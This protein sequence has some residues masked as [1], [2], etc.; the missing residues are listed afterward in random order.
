M[1]V[2]VMGNREIDLLIADVIDNQMLKKTKNGLLLTQEEIDLLKKYN[3]NVEDYGNIDELLMCI[4]D[5]LYV[6]P[7]LEEL[8]YLLTQL[9]E[10]KYY[11]QVNK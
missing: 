9:E 5:I 4:D 8:D 2:V 11:E 1:L 6:D 7:D 3:I 10:R